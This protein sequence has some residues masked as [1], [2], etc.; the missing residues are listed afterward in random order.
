MVPETINPK[1]P[2]NTYIR[3]KWVWVFTPGLG[4]YLQTRG[5]RVK[6]LLSSRA[7]NARAGV[8]TVCISFWVFSCPWY[9]LLS[10]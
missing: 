6:T 10:R 1:I 9:V 2:E 8:C 7:V 5:T 4:T 3:M